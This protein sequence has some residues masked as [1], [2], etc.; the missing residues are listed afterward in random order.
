MAE[1]LHQQMRELMGVDEKQ[2]QRWSPGYP[3]MRNIHLNATIHD[4]LGGEELI[5]V[6]LTDASEF[7]PTGTTGAVCS[8]HPEA[9]Y[10]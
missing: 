3:G 1:H 6:K 9:R 8:F 10:T 5:G 2:G 4:L 7:S